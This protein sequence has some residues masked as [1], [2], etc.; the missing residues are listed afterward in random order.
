MK[1]L[2]APWRSEY[3]EK[4]GK[5]EGCALCH[6][7]KR[8]DGEENLILMRTE[9]SFVVMN[10]YPYN[11]GHIMVCPIR[12]AGNFEDLD[13]DELFDLVKT[14]RLSITAVKKALKPHGYNLGLNSGRVAGAGI[15]GHL[16]FH[17]VPRWNG[18]TNF[19]P[20]ISDVKVVS[21]H[22]VQTYRKLKK[23]FSGLPREK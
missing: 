5:E 7:L 21:E 4:A 20:V 10:K 14:L 11:S 13:E 23:E 9:K 3:I 16:H 19:M 6:Q 1:K 2:W 18:D 12:H 17:L 8:E 15:E 22:L